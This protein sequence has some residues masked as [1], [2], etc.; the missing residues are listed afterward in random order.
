MKWLSKPFESIIEERSSKLVLEDSAIL[1][2]CSDSDRFSSPEQLRLSVKKETL[3]R[4]GMR[5]RLVE[6]GCEARHSGLREP[7]ERQ[8]LTKKPLKSIFR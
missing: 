8:S 2:G 6:P 4:P 3:D 5:E 1:K 7:S